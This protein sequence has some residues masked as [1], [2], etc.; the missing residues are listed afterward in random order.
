MIE[1]AIGIVALGFVVMAIAPVMVLNVNNQFRQEDERLAEN[2]TRAQFEFIKSQDYAW[3]NDTALYDPETE[4]WRHVSYSLA[5]PPP[6]YGIEVLVQPIHPDTH[7]C[8][9]L[10]EDSGLQRITVTIYGY[11]LAPEEPLK[12]LLETIDYKVSRSL[13]IKGFKIAG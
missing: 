5:E 11:G 13:E 9:P 1:V 6:Q 4:H 10:G 12:H 3:G 7:D 8:L 2:L